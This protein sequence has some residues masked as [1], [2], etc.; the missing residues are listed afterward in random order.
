M[1]TNPEAATAD[2]LLLAIGFLAL[3]KVTAQEMADRYSV[4]LHNACAEY[5]S[6]QEVQA[7][8]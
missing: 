3:G 8:Q 6:R 4:H 7:Q 1:A 5:R 2:E